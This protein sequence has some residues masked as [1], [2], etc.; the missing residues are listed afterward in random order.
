MDLLIIFLAVAVGALV[1]GLTG[2]GLPTVAIPVIAVFFGVERAVVVMAIP[3]ALTNAWLLW[4]H[5]RAVGE[6]RGLGILW[7]TGLVGAV[8]G[9]WLLVR[10]DDRILALVLAGIILI[11]VAVYALRPDF[12]LPDRLAARLSGPVGF[13]SGIL[14]GSTGIS[15][16]L[17]ATFLHSMRLPLS[18]YVFSLTLMF[19]SLG[20][21][22]ITVLGGLGLYT[23]DRLLE[24]ALA[25]VPIVLV[26]PVGIRLAR[27]I[28]QRAFELLTLGVLLATALR[29]VYDGMMG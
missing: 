25:L 16:P 14:Q 5:R 12:R 18:A 15:A 2:M 21:V 8:L 27:R 7:A 20:M 24:S 23:S 29:L 9:T 19:L 17:L 13:S 4:E 26:M 3:V 11:Y 28:S 22:Q 10:L 6:V 1:K